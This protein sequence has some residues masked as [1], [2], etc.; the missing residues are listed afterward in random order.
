MLKMPTA[1]TA[2]R[3]RAA[4]AESDETGFAIGAGADVIHRGA[5]AFN[6]FSCNDCHSP[7][8]DAA[9]AWVV[10]LAGVG[11]PLQVRKGRRLAARTMRHERRHPGVS[12]PRS[13][14]G[15]LT[16][17]PRTWWFFELLAPSR[18]H[19]S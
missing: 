1:G 2:T 12:I 11:L 8:A 15:V 9:G 16:L 3:P 10:A 4:V 5:V 6:K 19:S 13:V 7:K 14:A 18:P 17:W